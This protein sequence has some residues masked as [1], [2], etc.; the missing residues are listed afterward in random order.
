MSPLDEFVE[1]VVLVDAADAERG[2]MEKIEAHRTGSL[3]RAFS[4]FVVDRMG[5]LLLQRR[6]SGKYHSGGKWANTCCG[7]PRLGEPV[8]RAAARRLREEMGLACALDHAGRFLY[9]AELPGGLVEHEVDHVFVGRFD[10]DPRPDPSEVEEW[11]WAGLEALEAE[12]EADPGR[13]AVWVRQ[14]LGVAR[15]QWPGR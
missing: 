7:H 8:E 12:I 4:V 1:R 3:H 2:S 5:R 11:R 14:A 6:A 9:R 13:F 10:G 15:R